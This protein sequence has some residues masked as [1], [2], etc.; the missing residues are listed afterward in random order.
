[1]KI[2]SL[3][4][5][6]LAA[7]LAILWRRDA[8]GLI[9]ASQE[10]SE[11][12]AANADLKSELQ[13]AAAAAAERPE[14]EPVPE[15]KPKEKAVPATV[16]RE[17]TATR[18]ELVKLLDEKQARLA[19]ARREKQE[20]ERKLLESE[21]AAAA[22]KAER[23]KHRESLRD[24][25]DRLDTATRVSQAMEAELSGRNDRA[26]RI[27]SA[28]RELAAKAAESSKRAE[29]LA[30]LGEEIEDLARRRGT[31]LANLLRRYRE[32]TDLYR[33]VALRQNNPRETG[34]TAGTDLSRIQNAVMLA[35]D[36]MRQL[37]TLD[38]QVDRLRK[39]LAAAR[40]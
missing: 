15:E 30:K 37:H 21:E 3:A 14:P 10:A 40:R 27:D 33:A 35:E 9:R 25:Q 12:R 1:M 26:V 11:L 34:V 20:L 4:L 32:L 28:N 17:D 7:A 18:D 24:L 5:T 31:Y 19:E 36:D 29:R 6:V 23:D 2:A 8:A 13:R 16:V 39:E 38:A 22:A